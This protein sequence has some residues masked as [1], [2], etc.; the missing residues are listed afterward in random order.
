MINF[1]EMFQLYTEKIVVE[2]DTEPQFRKK[3]G[4]PQRFLW[5]GEWWQVKTVH[6]EWRTAGRL[7][8]RLRFIGLARIHFRVEVT[9]GRIFDIYFDPRGKGG[10]WILDREL[11]GADYIK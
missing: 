2:F 9:A 5:R 6:L 7:S 10:T 8:Q 1:S 11:L 4:C 3:P